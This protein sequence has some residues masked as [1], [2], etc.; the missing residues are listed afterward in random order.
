MNTERGTNSTVAKQQNLEAVKRLLFR[1]APISRSEMA[2]AL[3]LTPATLTNITSSL[4][5]LG[6]IRETEGDEKQPTGTKKAGRK[7][8]LL[9]LV[10]DVFTV[11]GL[12]LGRDGTRYV[13]TDLRGN[14]L[15]EGTFEVMSDNYTVMLHQL[16]GILAQLRQTSGSLWKVLLGIGIVV[17]GIVDPVHGKVRNHG[18]ERLSWCDKP[19]AEE[20]SR[21][22]GLDTV[23]E[24]NVRGRCYAAGLFHPD[25]LEREDTF[26][27]CHISYGIACPQVLNNRLLSGM[28]M[29][30]G[31]IG[32]MR[33]MTGL[34]E[35]SL[36]REATNPK[37]S[38]P[39]RETATLEALSA[40]PAILDSCRQMMRAKKNTLLHELCYS[41][42][43]LT[44]DHVL[45]ARQGKDPEVC[46]IMEEAMFYTGIA[47]SNMADIMNPH[48][49]L[50]SGPLSADPENIRIIETVLNRYAF[51]PADEKIRVVPFDMGVY[52]GALGAA[53]VCIEQVFIKGLC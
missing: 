50:F 3:G 22:T 46:R 17:P 40:V 19:L 35:I 27:L 51:L 29:A 24:N 53:A 42:E 13:F 23:L 1:Y 14:V 2:K 36:S 16:Q 6:M 45:E 10:P 44:L 11:L 31:E 20:I 48:L 49:I 28:D 38:I 33:L 21:F 41:P 43:E 32:K 26:A 37:E 8:I 7:K 47:L 25:L 30:A 9:D 4:L 39:V 34:P 52:A 15:Q 5:S 12:S 18:Q